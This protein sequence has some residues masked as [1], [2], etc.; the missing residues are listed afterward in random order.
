MDQ[1]ENKNDVDSQREDIIHKEIFPSM[2]VM[3]FDSNE[4][5]YLITS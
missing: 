3:E 2:K 1:E 4:Y 5:D